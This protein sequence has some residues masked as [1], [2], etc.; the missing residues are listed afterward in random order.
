MLVAF[1]ERRPRGGLPALLVQFSKKKVVIDGVDFWLVD[2][3]GFKFQPYRDQVL[4]RIAQEFHQ[5][6]HWLP[7]LGNPF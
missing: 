2:G 1:R 7:L 6:P 5:I 3:T 4:A